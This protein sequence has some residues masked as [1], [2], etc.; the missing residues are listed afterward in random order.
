MPYLPI[1][2]L[3]LALLEFVLQ[4]GVVRGRGD[5]RPQFIFATFQLKQSLEELWHFRFDSFKQTEWPDS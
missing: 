5:Q 4:V 2:V 3:G 1:G